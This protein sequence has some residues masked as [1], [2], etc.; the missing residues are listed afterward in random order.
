VALFLQYT[1]RT[2][3]TQ[4]QLVVRNLSEQSTT[5]TIPCIIVLSLET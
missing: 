2:V 3:R 1:A 4:G 5:R